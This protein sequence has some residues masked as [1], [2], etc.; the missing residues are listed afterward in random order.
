L[1]LIRYLSK[2]RKRL[3]LAEGRYAAGDGTQVD[4]LQARVAITQARAN[5]LEANYSYN[6]ASAKLRQASGQPDPVI[7]K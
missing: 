3:S 5:H 1:G 2:L 6:G 7:R 4:V